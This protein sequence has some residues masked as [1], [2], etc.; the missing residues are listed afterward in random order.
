MSIENIKSEFQKYMESKGFHVDVDKIVGD[1]EIHRFYMP[2]DADGSKNGAYLLHV[3]GVPNGLF[4]TW[5]EDGTNGLDHKWIGKPEKELTPEERDKFKQQ[6]E[7]DK[8]HVD[9]ERKR[10]EE[11]RRQKQ[12]EAANLA[13]QIWNDGDADPKHVSQ[14]LYLKAKFIQPHGARISTTEGYYKG[15]LMYPM[16]NIFGEIRSLLFIGPNGE[17]RQMKGGEVNGTLYDM[18]GE[19][20]SLECDFAEGIATGAS[21]CEATGHKVIVTFGKSNMPKVAQALENLMKAN[22]DLLK[23]MRCRMCADN[24]ADGG[25]EKCAKEAAAILGCRV[26]VPQFTP[27]Q[28]AE[29]GAKT[30]G[31]VPTDFN[32]LHQLAGLEEVKKQIEKVPALNGE[33][34]KT[35]KPVAFTGE[36]LLALTIPPKQ[37]VLEPVI[38]LQGL[39]MLYADRGVG[40]TFAALHMAL[41]IASGTEVFKWNAPEK[42]NVLYIDGEMPAIDMQMRLDEADATG[43][44]PGRKD[45]FKIINYD[46][47]AENNYYMP[48]LAIQEGW[49]YIAEN[50]KWADVVIIDSISTMMRFK[51]SNNEDEWK[52]VQDWL[53][54]LRAR[55]KTVV[56]LHH[57]NKTGGS[58][59]SFARED[60]M[61]TVIELKRP[62]DYTAD[63]GAR[64]NVNLSKARSVYGEQA[65]PFEARL[66][67]GCWE[68]GEVQEVLSEEERLAQK[69]RNMK[70]SGMTQQAIAQELG[71]SQSNVSKIMKKYQDISYEPDELPA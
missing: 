70:A 44:Y 7:K 17:K 18:A 51:D 5:K 42:R 6:Q 52:P 71:T 32:D 57:T 58:R 24:D 1:G 35:I 16:K 46:L 67:D 11:E 65:E 23:G 9:E 50:V 62:L 19:S 69:M 60:I 13:V 28:I 33:A 8:Q 55:G 22:P 3:D 43:M 25:G 26:A 49:N 45:N 66:K 63:Q 10:C 15:W 21:I 54:T 27:K 64:F 59:G 4:G 41:A 2:G 34:G 30:G 37:Y 53:K 29:F 12:D 48:N 14:H 39:A 61:D 20:G 31:K 47:Q 68:I 38:P 56:L 40:K 36:E